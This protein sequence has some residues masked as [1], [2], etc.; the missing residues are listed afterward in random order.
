[1]K[2]VGLLQA[3]MSSRRLPGKVLLPVHGKPLLGYVLERLRRSQKISQWVIAT[4]TDRA[5]D[6][7]ADFCRNHDVA[8][9]RGSQDDVALRLAEAAKKFNAE[10]LA[11]FCADS[12]YYDAEVVDRVVDAFETHPSAQIVTNLCPRSFPRGQSI[13]IIR[14]ETLMAEHAGMSRPE[15]REH[16]FPYFYEKKERFDIVNVVNSAGDFSGENHCVDTAEDMNLFSLFVE[17]AAESRTNYGW[18]EVSHLLT[19]LRAGSALAEKGRS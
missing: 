5:D 18:K 3:R 11:R 17:R 10:Y 7:V 6:P 15:D 13:E 8:C 16:V 9:F 1:M 2:L 4:S 14:T 12:P 19:S